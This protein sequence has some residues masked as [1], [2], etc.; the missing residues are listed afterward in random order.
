MVLK[1]INPFNLQLLEEYPLDTPESLIEKTTKGEKAF[2]L[3]KT[4]SFAKRGALFNTCADLLETRKD[5]LA[6]LMALEMGKP[7][8]EG[9]SEIEK[10]AW[11]CKFY[12]EKAHDFL[13]NEYIIS[14]ASSSYIAYQPLGLILAVMPWNFPFWQVFRFAAPALMAGNTAILKHASNVTGCSLAIEKLFRD[15]GFPEGVFQSVLVE[16]ADVADLIASNKIVAVTLTGSEAAG[17]AV[18]ARAGKFIKK[19][20]LELGG[21]DPFIVL[22]DAELD[23]AANTAVRARFLN[24]GQSCIAAKRFIVEDKVHDTFVALVKEKVQALVVGDPLD[25]KTNIGPLARVDLAEGVVQQITKS[26]AK[27]ATLL[28]ENTLIDRKE[29]T[30]MLAPTILTNAAIGM[31]VFDEEV[32][33][34]VMAIARVKGLEEAIEIAN[35][36]KYGLGASIWTENKEKALYA[37]QKIEAGS[38][39]VNGMVKS[40]PRLPFG[41]VKLSGYGRELSYYGIQEFCNAKTVWFK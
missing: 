24:T 22:A 6:G 17:S 19:V 30:A 26:I 7:L 29:G 38:V 5:H 36:T 31:P 18:A 12:A 33:G 11:V 20:V 39:F 3:W 35:A 9:I 40:D 23:L 2:K 16:A 14:D 4:Q 13:K 25:M 10:C 27:G 15:A 8:T 21:S 37:I 1:S 34:P 41:G 32:F 28:T